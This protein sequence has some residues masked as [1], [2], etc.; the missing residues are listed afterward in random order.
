MEVP[1]PCR[2][3]EY[4]EVIASVAVVVGGN[5]KICVDAESFGIERSVRAVSPVPDAAPEDTYICLAVTVIVPDERSVSILAKL[6]TGI[7]PVDASEPVP[8]AVRRAKYRLVVMP[9]TVE[10]TNLRDIARDTELNIKTRIVRTVDPI[11]IP[12]RRPEDRDI[13]LTVPVTSHQVPEY[14]PHLRNA[15]P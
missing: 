9:V 2:W 12:V 5:G 8:S 11:P 13:R 4:G 15:G 10:I 14:P 1:V 7:L 6:Y 3:A